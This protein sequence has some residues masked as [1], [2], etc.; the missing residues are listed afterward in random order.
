[1][2]H[3]A[4]QHRAVFLRAPFQVTAMIST[5]SP[6]DGSVHASGRAM[7][8]DY[9]RASDGEDVHIFGA[10]LGSRHSG[11]THGAGRDRV[12]VLRAPLPVMSMI[13]MRSPD[14]G[15]GLDSGSEGRTT[16]SASVRSR[17][18][19][20]ERGTM[21]CGDTLVM[22]A[23]YR[24]VW[25]R[26]WRGTRVHVCDTQTPP[27]SPRVLAAHAV[28]LDPDSGASAA[29]SPRL[30]RPHPVLA[31]QL[32]A[33]SQPAVLCASVFACLWRLQSMTW[34]WSLSS[35]LLHEGA[36]QEH[37]HADWLDSDRSRR[38]RPW[39]P[40]R[41]LQRLYLREGARSEDGEDEL[42]DQ[43]GDGDGPW[44]WRE[45]PG[46]RGVFWAR[47]AQA[48]A[49]ERGRGHRIPLRV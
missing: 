10:R 4:G 37:L 45:L 24:M 22:V 16:D 46:R 3:G 39:S 38:P 25:M 30:C 26:I 33:S 8:G 5:R 19:Y 13:P 9:A 18:S 34:M 29:P 42:G 43:N 20:R 36:T 7:R 15:V 47:G 44:R 17:A 32:R 49:A 48:D 35:L 12:V 2:E 41:P 1:M 11:S 28:W 31:E 14:D 21:M 40:P 27:S 6:D 23:V